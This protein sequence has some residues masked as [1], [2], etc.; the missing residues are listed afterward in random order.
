MMKFIELISKAT[1]TPGSSTSLE[2]LNQIA[3]S[4]MPIKIKIK[5]KIKAKC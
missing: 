1:I 3:K 2:V 4:K 5:A